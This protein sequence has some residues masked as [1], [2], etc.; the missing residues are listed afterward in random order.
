M[1]VTRRRSC[2]AAGIAV[3]ALATAAL[4]A[5]APAHAAP[6]APSAVF[7]VS[8]PDIVLQ[9]SGLPKQRLRC[10]LIIG[11]PNRLSSS[12]YA[13]RFTFRDTATGSITLRLRP[14]LGQFPMVYSTQASCNGW[15]A[16]PKRQFYSFHRLREV[17]VTPVGGQAL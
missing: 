3:A 6:A 2:S 7:S 8:G 12:S 14:H 4:P 13:D 16:S 9:V 17:L 11:D 10:E 5:L 1:S 15:I